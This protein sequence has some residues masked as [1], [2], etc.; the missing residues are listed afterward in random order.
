MKKIFASLVSI[1]ALN[2]CCAQQAT[3]FTA[4]DCSGTSWNLFTE[5]STGKV[6]ILDWV[7]PCDGC[8]V[9]T[10]TADSALIQLNV[11]YP[12]KI[13]LWVTSDGPPNG[14]L[15]VNNWLVAKHIGASASFANAGNEIDQNAYGGLGMPHIVVIGPDQ[16]IY[17]NEKSGTATGIQTAVQNAIDGITGINAIQNTQTLSISPNPAKDKISIQSS[18]PVNKISI[19]DL[20]G[21][22]VIE[23][24]YGS[25]K[26]NPVVNISKLPA[27]TYIVTVTDAYNKSSIQKI[28]KE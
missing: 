6:V 23:E 22:S 10:R 14:C 28:V 17:F 2:F 27:G 20:L 19:N 3:D 15:V 26:A 24:N 16:H 25:G 18:N 1:F 8:I 13:K 21:Q 4:V 9:G 11:T 12:N 5:L 7:E